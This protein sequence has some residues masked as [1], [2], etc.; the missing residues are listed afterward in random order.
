MVW[1][2]A[3]VVPLIHL[4]GQRY[5]VREL[6]PITLSPGYNQDV[7]TDYVGDAPVLDFVIENDEAAAVTAYLSG[8][9]QTDAATGDTYYLHADHLGSTW[10]TSLYT[11]SE[12]VLS[13]AA[14]RTAFGE[15]AHIY[16]ASPS[17]YGYAGAWGY[18]EHDIVN[19]LGAV[20]PDGRS[21]SM[22]NASP[23]AGLPFMHVGHRYYDPGSG[24]FLQR[25]PIGIRG[26]PNVYSYVGSSPTGMVDP[27]GLV[28]L[29]G[30]GDRL[31]NPPI[32]SRPGRPGIIN[33]GIEPIPGYVYPEGPFPPF[34]PSIVLGLTGGDDSWLDDPATVRQVQRK[35]QKTSVM[36][37]SGVVI[38]SL[39]VAAGTKLVLSVG[40][41][42][43]NIWAW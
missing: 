25:D 37:C 13:A 11:G 3:R 31:T 43:A 18:Q 5:L 26:G 34:V 35:L 4:P 28:G 24:R 21:D 6:D 2:D 12:Y 7:W 1:T 41:G 29:G 39:P 36:I 9:S 42:G 30:G 16:K 38:Y 15:R 14:I 10:Y 8:I 22:M 33:G 17:R 20:T 27:S 19:I 40:A 23:T 32:G